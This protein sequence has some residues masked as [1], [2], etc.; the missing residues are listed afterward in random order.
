MRSSEVMV[1]RAGWREVR[2]QVAGGA[3]AARTV[4]MA[5]EMETREETEVLAGDRGGFAVCMCDG[6]GCGLRAWPRTSLRGSLREDGGKPADRHGG[7][8]RRRGTP[9]TGSTRQLTGESGKSAGRE[10]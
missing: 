1:P 8:G 9:L 5:V 7:S 2:R 10:A 4:L 3:R 6:R